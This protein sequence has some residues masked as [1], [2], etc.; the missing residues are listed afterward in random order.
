MR[1][2]VDPKS[3]GLHPRT[4][5]VMTGSDEFALV[6]NR[7]SR[8]IMKDAKAILKKVGAIKARVPDAAVSLET[9]APVCSKSIQFLEEHDVTVVSI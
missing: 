2:Q 6:M 8:V 5:L 4:V 7:K 1:E 3:Y 9:T